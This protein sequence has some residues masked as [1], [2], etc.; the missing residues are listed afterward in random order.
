VADRRGAGQG[1]SARGWPRGWARP[2]GAGLG[3]A[4]Y[5]VEASGRYVR[6]VTLIEASILR[7]NVVRVPNT[8]WGFLLGSIFVGRYDSGGAVCL[9]MREVDCPAPDPVSVPHSPGYVRELGEKKDSAARD[10][11]DEAVLKDGDEL[12]GI[13]LFPG[14][15]PLP[16]HA[17]IS[18]HKP[19]YTLS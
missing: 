10:E 9:F 1:R 14:E 8:Y 15:V 6:W 5:A 12:S 19:M 2:V 3:K 17:H 4:W 16:A 13:L 11:K 7:G 18:N